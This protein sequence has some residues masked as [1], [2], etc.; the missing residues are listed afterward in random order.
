MPRAAAYFGI[1]DASNDSA[2]VRGIKRREACAATNNS[3]SIYDACGWI[4]RQDGLSHDD[5]AVRRDKVCW[6]ITIH[7]SLLDF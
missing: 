7:L 1:N 6:S 5:V 4:G 3:A 2:A